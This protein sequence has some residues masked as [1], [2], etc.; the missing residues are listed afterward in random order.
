MDRGNSKKGAIFYQ[1]IYDVIT[2]IKYETS[3][4]LVIFQ[5]CSTNP[6][7]AFILAHA[8]YICSIRD[9]TVLAHF[10]CMAASVEVVYSHNTCEPI[11]YFLVLSMHCKCSQPASVT[12]AIRAKF[13]LHCVTISITWMVSQW[14]DDYKW[15]WWWWWC[16]NNV[17]LK[18]VL[19][20]DK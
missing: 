2:F 14:A 9:A 5:R 18:C 1:N 7:M 19:K 13:T 4:I 6:L 20:C 17:I 3:I 16:I 10:S 8:G 11:S 12:K 15:R